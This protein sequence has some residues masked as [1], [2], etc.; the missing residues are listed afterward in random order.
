MEHF[1]QIVALL[2]QRF[3]GLFSCQPGRHG[4]A[5]GLE[6]RCSA[7]SGYVFVYE[8]SENGRSLLSLHESDDDHNPEVWGTTGAEEVVE[9]LRPWVL[10]PQRTLP[11]PLDPMAERRSLE[12]FARGLIARQDVKCLKLEPKTEFLRLL[13]DAGRQQFDRD[14]ASL[15]QER[16]I[17]HFPWD[18]AGRLELDTTVLLGTYEATTAPGRDRELCLAAVGPARRRD[19]Q[20]ITIQLMDLIV[21]NQTYRWERTPWLWKEVDALPSEFWGAE[22]VQEGAASEPGDSGAP[23]APSQTAWGYKRARSLQLLDDGHIEEALAL[24]GVT[25]SPDLHRLLGGER[26]KSPACCAHPDE[27]WTNLLVATLRQSAPWLL[28]KAVL[29]EAE[30]LQTWA[31]QKKGRPRR[32]PNLKLL[33]FPGQHHS[34]KASLMLTGDADGQNPRLVIEATA[35]NARL[36]DTAW[37]RPIAVDFLRRGVEVPFRSLAV[38]APWPSTVIQLAEALHAGEDCAFALRDALH[39]AGYPELAENFHENEHPKKTGALKH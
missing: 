22:L 17:A 28:P 3:A 25:L 33:I 20:R 14:L 1:E 29:D 30:R 37:K 9:R 6:I 38:P 11:R 15:S 12:R 39:E 31:A 36:A 27:K 7:R 21:V 10:P 32:A 26:I 2:N 5:K 4:E 35:S 19:E 24:Y 13:T 23:P 8:P 18:L 34:R 16:I